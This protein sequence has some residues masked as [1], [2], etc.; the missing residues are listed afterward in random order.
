[1]KQ[2]EAV[3]ALISSFVLVTPCV[4]ASREEEMYQ[5]NSTNELVVPNAA[6]VNPTIDGVEGYSGLFAS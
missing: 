1:M 6:R 2:M 3:H 5:S 4:H